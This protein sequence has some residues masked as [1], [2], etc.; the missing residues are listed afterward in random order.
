MDAKNA[1]GLRFEGASSADATARYAEFARLGAGSAH[2]LRPQRACVF[3]TG[4]FMADGKFS[5]F[6]SKIHW[7]LARVRVKGTVP[8]AS[9]FGFQ[10]NTIIPS[11]G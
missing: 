6:W 2:E 4:V 8:D 5:E 1:G 7:Q 3:M 10:V 11:S 9:E